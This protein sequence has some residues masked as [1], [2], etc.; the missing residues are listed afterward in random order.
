LVYVFVPH[1][2]SDEFLKLVKKLLADKQLVID[3]KNYLGAPFNN[4]PY[5][6]IESI[7][8]SAFT[9]PQSSIYPI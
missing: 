7:L 6:Q 3:G 1:K 9:K 4:V 5:S 8:L 2:S